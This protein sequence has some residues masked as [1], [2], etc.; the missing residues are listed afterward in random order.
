MRAWNTRSKGVFA[1][2]ISNAFDPEVKSSSVNKAAT[3]P[4]LVTSWLMAIVV[5]HEAHEGF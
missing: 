5:Q 3:Q 1:E 4:F 2:A